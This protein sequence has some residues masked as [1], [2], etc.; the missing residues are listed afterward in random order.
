MGP[1]HSRGPSAR[2]GTTLSTRPQ[3]RR[4]SFST[5]LRRGRSSARGAEAGACDTAVGGGIEMETVE[6]KGVAAQVAEQALVFRS[7]ASVLH[8]CFDCDAACLMLEEPNNSRV[9]SSSE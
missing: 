2:P 1:R 8:P 3:T 4:M 5:R 9:I 6:P 7:N